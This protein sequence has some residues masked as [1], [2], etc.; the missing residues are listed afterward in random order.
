MLFLCGFFAS[1]RLCVRFSFLVDKNWQEE[2]LW[3]SMAR[4]KKFMKPSRAGPVG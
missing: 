2:I 4:D 3:Q 1:L